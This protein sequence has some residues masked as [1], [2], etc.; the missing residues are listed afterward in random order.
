MTPLPLA[1]DDLEQDE[2]LEDKTTLVTSYLCSLGWTP[3]ESHDPGTL[4]FAKIYS[5]PQGRVAR[6]VVVI[7]KDEVGLEPRYVSYFTVTSQLNLPGKDIEVEKRAP[8]FCKTDLLRVLS[9]FEQPP[10]HHE[11]DVQECKVCGAPV[12]EYLDIDGATTCFD[13][14]R[15]KGLSL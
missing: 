8:A 3:K 1:I 12:P 9:H 7:Q 4:E 11:V 2:D 6:V 15:R 13:C 10:T 14:A 5:D